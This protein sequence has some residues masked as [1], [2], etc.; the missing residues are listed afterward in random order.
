VDVLDQNGFGL[1]GEFVGLDVKA[2]RTQKDNKATQHLKNSIQMFK[3]LLKLSRS[4]DRKKLQT[5]RTQRDY[6]AMEAY[7]MKHLLS[8]K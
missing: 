8:L 6:E 4:L 7:I 3:D 2:L 5:F 1:N